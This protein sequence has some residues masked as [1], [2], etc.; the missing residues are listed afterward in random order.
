MTASVRADEVIAVVSPKHQTLTGSRREKDR[1]ITFS[2]RY[3]SARRIT[4]GSLWMSCA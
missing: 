2:N 4:V 3:G 1:L